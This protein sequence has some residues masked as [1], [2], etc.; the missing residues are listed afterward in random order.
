M[1]R[2][3]RK[4]QFQN[5]DLLRAEQAEPGLLHL[6]FDDRPDGLFRQSPCVGD[7][8]HLYVG[9]CGRDVGVESAAAGCDDLGG[10]V[11]A[12]EIGVCREEG[13][14]P[15]LDFSQVFGIGRSLIAAARAAAVVID[16][17]RRPQKYLASVKDWPTL[18]AP[19]VRP[20]ATTMSASPRFGPAACAKIHRM[21]IYP[22]DSRMQNATVILNDF[23]KVFIALFFMCSAR[24][25]YF[26]GLAPTGRNGFFVFRC[27]SVL[28]WPDRL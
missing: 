9:C 14:D 11:L 15:R 2:V 22:I 17:R 6:F 21:S 4:V 19:T 28:R 12:G 18:A 23:Q 3:K 13:V 25:M 20:S 24:F 1:L 27:L 5:V 26:G 10:N 7:P 8:F 16:G